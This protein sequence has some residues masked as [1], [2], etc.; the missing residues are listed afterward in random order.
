MKIKNKQKGYEKN[1]KEAEKNPKTKSLIEFDTSF[2]CNI[3]APAVKQGD[4]V[5]TTSRFFSGKML[6]FA[7]IYLIS[8]ICDLVKTFFFPNKKTIEIY[9]KYQIDYIYPFHNLTDTDSTSIFFL[10]VCPAQSNIPDEKYRD[11]LFEVFAASG[12]LHKSDRSHEFWEKLSVR[13][14]TLKKSWGI[15]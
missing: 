12:I 5:K 2:A 4:A 1:L 14:V 6:M 9:E 13:D 8:S 15:T 10:F 7:K 3:K 11:C